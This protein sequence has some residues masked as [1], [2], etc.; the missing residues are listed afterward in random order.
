M[1]ILKKIFTTICIVL[2]LG[3]T[4]A[5]AGVFSDVNPDT[6]QG[7]AI[8]F[9]LNKGV[10]EGAAN[11]FPKRPITLAEFLA[12]GLQ[13]ADVNDLPQN[14][15]T[16]F[17]DAQNA[18]FTPY[19]AKADS[20][21]LLEDFKGENLLPNRA[22]TKGEAVKLGLKIFGVGVSLTLP[23]ENFGFTDVKNTHR[24]ARYIFRALKLGVIDPISNTEFGVSQRFTRGEAAELLYNLANSDTEGGGT[25][26]I[27]NGGSDV[28]GWQMFQSVWDETVNRFLW[29][30]KIDKT[31]MMQRAI[32]GAVNA[33]G[34]PYSAYLLPSKTT[35]INQDLSGK[36]E[37]IGAYLSENEAREVVVVAP[38]DGSPAQAAGIQSGDVI[39]AVDG[40][41]VGGVSV[42]AVS[43][44]I[45]GIAGTTVSLTIRRNG[46]QL[47]VSIKR[48][49]IEIKA[50]N[51]KFVDGVAVLKLTQFSSAVPAEF[52][53]A[54]K[55]I[56]AQHPKGIV[57]D[58]R[59]NG[60]GL[61]TAAVDVASYFL[62]E[63]SVVTKT[64]YREELS[65]FNA[66]QRTTHAPSFT[67]YKVAVLIN[68]G[69][70]SASEIVAAALQDQ[71]VATVVGETS[72]GKGV[73]QEINFF[74]DGTALK[75][76]VAHWLSPKE[77][78][79]EGKGITPD[80]AAVDDTATTNIDEALKRALNLF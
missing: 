60:G 40:K 42:E 20:L 56:I 80:I 70:A 58:L 55:E 31:E 77:Q 63:N 34:D 9:L 69:S 53:A 6:P 76:T 48:A 17:S 67:G 13:A 35:A 61:V 19:V 25:I 51:L 62:P 74:G 45:R 5:F 26:I 8:E 68:K 75:L 49:A 11:F 32:E 1:R 22:L 73:M 59:N 44:Q 3:N 46:S 12:M 38:I 21:S 57:L 16:R 43:A 28:P 64:Q 23:N 7:K 14:A 10:G 30:D 65:Q 72:F 79:I 41:S 52:A 66:T 78:P 39:I 71:G 33:L 27:Q 50:V 54:V 18:W 37:G 24:L 29:K 36:T 4:T 15:T 47:I 2:V